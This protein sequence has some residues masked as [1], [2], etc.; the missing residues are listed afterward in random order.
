MASVSSV[1]LAGA[2]P[3][4]ADVDLD[5]QNITA[6]SIE[7][8]LT[9]ATRA[10]VVVH[11]A[12]W[13]CDMPAIM[14]LARRRGLKVIEDCAQAHGA[15]IGSQ[16][17]GGFGD[18][19][20]WSFCQDKIMTT[21]GEGGM[22][23]TDDK[24]LWRAAWEFKD[25]GKSW[26]A[27]QRPER[28]LGFRWLHASFGSNW[29]LTE[30]QSALG[31]VQL[32]RMPSWNL[33]RTRNA[34]RL[35]GRLRRHP[36]LRVPLPPEHLT[37]AWYKLYAFVRPQ[38]LASGW[39]RDSLLPELEAEGIPALT[40]SCPEIYLEKAFE[41]TDFRP[42][43]RLPNARALGETSLMF[44]VHPTMTDADI[45]RVASAVD[46]ALARVERPR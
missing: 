3:L 37:H 20:A 35:A 18:V 26:E 6:E 22:L 12:G 23:T 1:V 42:P 44:M 9:P 31:L 4:F 40:G 8:V 24:A 30:M 34:L 15:R 19:A 46:R 2:R 28:E 27:V 41:G 14:S 38:A 21:G 36:A 5:S 13:P 10:I 7:A 11:L 32:A 16:P 39:S 25:H 17:V 29:R 43:A 33:A 45:D